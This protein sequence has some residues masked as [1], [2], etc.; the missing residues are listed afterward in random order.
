M[1][2]CHLRLTRHE[3]GEITQWHQVPFDWSRHV[4]DSSC[5]SWRFEFDPLRDRCCSSVDLCTTARLQLLQ[6]IT[7][8]RSS[9]PSAFWVK[10]PIRSADFQAS[11]SIAHWHNAC[12]LGL[13][14]SGRS[15][16]LW[17]GIVILAMAGRRECSVAIV[18]HI[19]SKVCKLRLVRVQTDSHLIFFEFSIYCID[20][21]C[22]YVNVCMISVLALLLLIHCVLYVLKNVKQNELWICSTCKPDQI[23]LMHSMTDHI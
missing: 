19:S 8:G 20:I 16:F 7:L 12:G 14:A 4:L 22:E 21:L 5:L 23:H 1:V 6:F 15:T 11:T 3:H 13:F 17:G 18:V 9:V 10:M 2:H